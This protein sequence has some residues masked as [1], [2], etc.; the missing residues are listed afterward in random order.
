M[1][2]VSSRPITFSSSFENSE[3]E[4]VPC[5]TCYPALPCAR[6]SVSRR[7]SLRLLGSVVIDATRRH[8][9]G[10]RRAQGGPAACRGGPRGEN[11][12][13]ARTEAGEGERKRE[14]PA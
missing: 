14:Q 5:K 6:F 9:R 12:A 8:H 7:Q 4:I 10:P 3:N 11:R 1:I 2:F 13:E